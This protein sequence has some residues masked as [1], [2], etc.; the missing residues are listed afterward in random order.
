MDQNFNGQNMQNGNGWQYQ[1][2]TQQYQNATQ[3]AYAQQAQ[4]QQAFG[5]NYGQ[6]Y[7]TGYG[8]Q[9]Q[10]GGQVFGND[11]YSN[12][13][14]LDN[15][16]YDDGNIVQGP[17]QGVMEKLSEAM[18]QEVIAK[19]FLYMVAALLVTA[20][21]A[22]SLQG[23]MYMWARENFTLILFAELGVAIA[24]NI[25]IKKGN[26]VITAILFTV[27]SFMTGI[28][29]GLI[30]ELYTQ[31]SVASVFVVTA[32]T[33]GIMAVYG[34]V[35]DADLSSIGS[36]LMMALIGILLASVV[37]IFLHNT[38][39]DM[40]ISWIGIGVFV[41]LTA[42]DTQKIKKK[43]RYDLGESVAVIALAGA[44]ELYLDFINLFLRLL[45]VMGKRK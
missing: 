42:Y 21:A 39:L 23:N 45:R 1:N 9:F 14:G 32:V 8:Q 41:G 24:S 25:M 37:N 6:Q 2:G 19:S 11:V 4:N 35:T 10:G 7:S 44:F 26:A 43:A 28:T 13:N 5:P 27:Y 17:T 15:N 29:L 12:A 40:I 33:F 18:A 31:T 3:Q 20:V 36:I 22:F 16:F 30:M 34:L 38:M